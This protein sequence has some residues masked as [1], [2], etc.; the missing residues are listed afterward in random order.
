MLLLWKT[1]GPRFH[2]LI[3]I[4]SFSKSRNVTDFGKN[5]P[6]GKLVILMVFIDVKKKTLL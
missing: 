6:S 5:G 1:G 2:I 3:L 4:E